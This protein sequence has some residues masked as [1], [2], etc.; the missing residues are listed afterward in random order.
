MLHFG[1]NYMWLASYS[2]SF[3]PALKY[4]MATLVVSL[5]PVPNIYYVFMDN[6]DEGWEESFQ[7]VRAFFF[8]QLI[9]FCIMIIH[10]LPTW[11]QKK[12]YNG[13][14]PVSVIW[15]QFTSYTNRCYWDLNLFMSFLWDTYC[16]FVTYTTNV[17]VKLDNS[18]YLSLF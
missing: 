6:N 7:V 14:V 3:V 8:V 11:L 17:N 9:F 2:H 13:H 18:I 12:R 5:S 15:N 16:K 1:D 4:R 10:I